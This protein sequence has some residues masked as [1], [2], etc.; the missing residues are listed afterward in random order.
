MKL[1]SEIVLLQPLLPCSPLSPLG[2]DFATVILVIKML[3]IITGT[4]PLSRL[5]LVNS[6]LE[7][8]RCN[9]SGG[10]ALGSVFVYKLIFKSILELL[11][12]N[13]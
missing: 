2:D 12:D 5:Y 13:V 7:S 11:W 10:F 9:A 1:V 3:L 8:G 4:T 6:L